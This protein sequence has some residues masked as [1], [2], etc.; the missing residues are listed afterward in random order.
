MKW[1]WWALIVLLVLLILWYFFIYR[2]N[3]KKPQG[4]LDPSV[5]R[6]LEDQCETLYNTQAEVDACVAEKLKTYQ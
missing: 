3:S 1:Y 2:K 5:K 6:Q 4:T